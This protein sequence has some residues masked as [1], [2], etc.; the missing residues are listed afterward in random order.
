MAT[1]RAFCGQ[2]FD[3]LTRQ[4]R[5][6]QPCDRKQWIEDG[7]KELMSQPLQ[8]SMKSMAI[9]GAGHLLMHYTNLPISRMQML[10]SIYASL[11]APEETESGLRS[12]APQRMQAA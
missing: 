1:M 9:E 10:E 7:L 11:H 6:L 4:G 5:E 3:A 8:A 12:R 2:W